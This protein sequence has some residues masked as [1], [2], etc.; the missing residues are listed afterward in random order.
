MRVFLSGL[1]GLT[2]V[3]GVEYVYVHVCMCVFAHIYV[4]VVK[5]L[6]SAYECLVQM[7]VVSVGKFVWV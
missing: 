3:P 7:F 1:C 6:W 5:S 2:I 4:G